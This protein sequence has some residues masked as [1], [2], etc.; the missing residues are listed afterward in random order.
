[1]PTLDPLR[2]FKLIDRFGTASAALDAL[3]D[4]A[5]RGGAKRQIKI[6]AKAEAER[7][8]EALEKVGGKFVAYGEAD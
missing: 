4:L 7:E 5:K 6:R 3:P 1:V 8:I 2:F